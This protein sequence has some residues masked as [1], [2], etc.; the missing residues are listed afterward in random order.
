MNKIKQALLSQYKWAKGENAVKNDQ[1]RSQ[2][3]IGSGQA[4]GNDKFVN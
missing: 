2:V 3:F 1:G 4:G